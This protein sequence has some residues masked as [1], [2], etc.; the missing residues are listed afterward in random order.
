MASRSLTTLLSHSGF[1]NCKGVGGHARLVALS[2][3]ALQS[4][5][6]FGRGFHQSSDPA[7]SRRHDGHTGSVSSLNL[8]GQCGVQAPCGLGWFKSRGGLL[9][10][11]MQTPVSWC[12][13]RSY[14]KKAK[15]EKGG[16][17]GKKKISLSEEELEGV[18][19]LNK[20]QGE[21]SDVAQ[22]LQQQMTQQVSVRTNIGAYDKLPI[23]TDDGVFPLV[24]LAQIAQK[25]PTLIVVNMATS[26]QYIKAVKDALSQSGLNVNPQQDGTTIFIPVPKVTRE[27]REGLA[28]NAKMIHDKAK[29]RL[30]DIHNK[31]TKKVRA[32]K[33]HHSEDIVR[34]AQDLVL[35]EMHTYGQQ[36]DSMLA[37]KQQ[38]LL[39]GK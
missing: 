21:M 10:Q 20:L 1:V 34:A 31:H 4:H 18:L 22:D 9:A 24:Q 13:V 30:R 14:A 39:G 11:V 17:G 16:K 27:H 28:K 32:A 26:P 25:N 33:D 38:E 29:T 37:T 5:S 15:K 36:L 23:K 8:T 7:P 6:R 19:D 2:C 35:E 12:V 3:G